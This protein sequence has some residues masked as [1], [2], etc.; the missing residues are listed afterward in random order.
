MSPFV[1]HCIQ[2]NRLAIYWLGSE[3]C[4]RKLYEVLIT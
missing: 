2:A 1:N 4:T 3:G